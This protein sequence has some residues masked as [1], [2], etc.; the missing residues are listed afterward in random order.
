MEKVK[1][2]RKNP[3]KGLFGF[4]GNIFYDIKVL[5]HKN[6]PTKKQK[7][8]TIKRSDRLFYITLMAIPVFMFVFSQIYINLNSF[9]LAFEKYDRGNYIFNGIENFITVWSDWQ[10]DMFRPIWR[11][12]IVSYLIS[13]IVT[14]IIPILFSYAIYKKCYGYKLFKVILYLPSIISSVI[15]VT[16]FRF[17]MEDIVPLI[18]EKFGVTIVG[19]IINQNKSFPVVFGY[20][21]FMSFGGGLLVQLGA[22]N[23]VDVSVTEAAYMDG[24]GFWGELWHVVLP[25]T[26]QTIFIF[27]IL[28]FSSLFTNDLGLYTFYSTGAIPKI[29]TIGYYFTINNI[30]NDPIMYPYFSAWGLITSAIAIPVTFLLRYLIYH[31]GPQED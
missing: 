3:L 17:M 23:S 13:A 2:E 19:L 24:V 9:K 20:Y 7:T 18:G 1:K 30:K 16:I 5:F 28:G 10:T 15:T 29:Q 27:F 6:K 11:N 14:M 21:L 8:S 25:A 12:S 22:M 4:F 26:Y 31:F